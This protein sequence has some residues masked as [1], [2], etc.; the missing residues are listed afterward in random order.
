MMMSPSNDTKTG[1]SQ[2]Q[3]YVSEL[4]VAGL[5]LV[6][7]MFST[8]QTVHSVTKQEWDITY[9]GNILHCSGSAFDNRAVNVILLI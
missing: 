1:N 6:L 3:V 8:A 9:N 4:V 2:F 7:V 5:L